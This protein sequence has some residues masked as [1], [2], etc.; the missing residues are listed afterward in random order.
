[1]FLY[2]FLINR[3]FLE[4]LEH[5]RFNKIICQFEQT[6]TKEYFISFAIQYSYVHSVNTPPSISMY[7]NIAGMN[8]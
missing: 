6:V 8:V 7:V 5:R 1:M 3:N 2:A 4:R